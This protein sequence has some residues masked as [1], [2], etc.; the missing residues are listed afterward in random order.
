MGASGSYHIT[1]MHRDL[2]SEIQRLRVQVQLTWKKESRTLAWFGLRDGMSILEPGSGPG[3]ITGLLL[4]LLPQSSVTSVEIDPI[5]ITQA[6]DYLHEKRGDRLCIEEASVMDTGLPENSYDFAVARFLFQHL[7]DPV[8]AAK[9]I[10]RVLKPNGKLVIIDTDYGLWGIMDPTFP[11][12]KAIEEKHI[13]SHIA[14][15]GNPY[16]GR[17][18][19]RILQAAG[20]QCLDLEGIVTHSD[21]VGL[22]MVMPL[23]DADQLLPSVKA[24]VV[25]EAEYALV[26]ASRE[27]FVTYPRALILSLLLLA[28]GEKL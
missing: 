20:F 13:E 8:G 3:F 12:V 7:P 17:Q 22:K 18:L 6:T 14:Q 5:M 9:E 2:E 4:D 23:Y 26:R 16:F 21:T 27:Q 28:C 10:F 15:G 25:S 11:G 19:L 1:Q 24:G